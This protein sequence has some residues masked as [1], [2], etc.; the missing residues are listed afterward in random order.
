MLLNDNP[1]NALILGDLHPNLT[2]DSL[3]PSKSA[4][5]RHLDRFNHFAG[6][7]NVTNTETDIHTDRQTDRPRYSVCIAAMRPKID[8]NETVGLLPVF[9]AGTFVGKKSE[10]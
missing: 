7:T 8:P 10:I 5:K 3:G 9:P 1:K 6:L 2:H 4:P